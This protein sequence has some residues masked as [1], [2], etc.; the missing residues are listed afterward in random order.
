MNPDIASLPLRDIHL[1]DSVSWWPLAAGWWILLALIAIAIFTA[2]LYK[3]RRAKRRLAREAMAQFG[4][5]MEAYQSNHDSGQL[6]GALSALLRAVSI[7]LF[8]RQDVAALTGKEWLQFLDQAVN[9]KT[10]G[11]GARF[12]SELGQH[13]VTLPY[14]KTAS[15]EPQQLQNLLFLCRDWLRQVCKRRITAGTL[16]TGEH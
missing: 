7:S 9:G 10:S 8:P 1:P 15:I 4:R 14:N 13:L 6:V 5:L 16:L 2:Y 11:A 3:A 12:D